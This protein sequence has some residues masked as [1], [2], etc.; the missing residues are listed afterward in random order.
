[1]TCLPYAATSWHICTAAL[2]HTP[3]P[4]TPPLPP[5]QV[6][7]RNTAGKHAGGKKVTG[8]AALPT[9]PP[10]FLVTTNDSRLRLLDGYGVACKFKGLKNSST[11]I[12]AAIAQ[13]ASML[14][15]GSDDGWVYLWELGGTKPGGGKKD[16]CYCTFQAHEGGAATAVAFLSPEVCAMQPSSSGATGGGSTRGGGLAGTMVAGG[17]VSPAAPASSSAAAAGAAGEPPTASSA[18]MSSSSI[19][20]AGTGLPPLPP[21]SWGAP[22]PTTPGGPSSGPST[23]AAAAAGGAGGTT[24][25]SAAC[26]DGGTAAMPSPHH[27][28]HHHQQQQQ[29]QWV[30]KPREATLRQVMV[31]GGWNGGVRV[32]ELHGRS[33]GSNHPHGS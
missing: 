14:G 9:S 19:V 7:V 25:C 11:Q 3:M 23:A 29:Q 26:S 24:P 21:P 18:S 16:G 30:A 32:W 10:Q 31:T 22:S 15:C 8:V 5:A 20:A 13:D 17:C 28:S 6:D 2:A 1:M 27:A 12:R 4:V 33:G